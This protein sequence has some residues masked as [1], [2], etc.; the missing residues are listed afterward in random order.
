MIVYDELNSVGWNFLFQIVNTI[1]LIGLVALSIYIL[2]LAIRT[3]RL[4]FL[5]LEYRCKE[6]GLIKG[7][8]KKQL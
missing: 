5:Y 8:E 6:L 4:A 3:L 1:L 2:Y 7:K